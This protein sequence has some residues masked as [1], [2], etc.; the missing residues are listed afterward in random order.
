MARSD[1]SRQWV[2]LKTINLFHTVPSEKSTKATLLARNLA[3]NGEK[4]DCD[5]TY[6][7]RRGRPAIMDLTWNSTRTLAASS[8]PRPLMTRRAISIPSAA[9]KR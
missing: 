2:L 3:D 9:Q 1:E 7:L 8:P 6:C 5:T 4:R